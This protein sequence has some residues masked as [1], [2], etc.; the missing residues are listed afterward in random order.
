[1]EGGGVGREVGDV[2][3]EQEAAVAGLGVNGGA[4]DAF[5]LIHDLP[6]VFDP[7][8]AVEEYLDSAEGEPS[9]DRD[10]GDSEE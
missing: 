10:D 8:L 6:G 9:V 3:G 1:V 2:I 5:D 4:H 7:V